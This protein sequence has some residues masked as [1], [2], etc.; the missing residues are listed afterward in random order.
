MNS[1]QFTTYVQG[2]VGLKLTHEMLDAIEEQMKQDDGTMVTQLV[3]ILGQ[4]G[5]KIST[6]TVE[7]ARKTLGWTLPSYLIR[8]FSVTTEVLQSSATVATNE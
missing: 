2:V 6:L 7:R 3:K 8:I 4:R 5:F 1:L